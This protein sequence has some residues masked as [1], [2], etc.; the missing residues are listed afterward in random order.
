MNMNM[1]AS[2]RT[3]VEIK[4]NLHQRLE[5]LRPYDSMSWH[6]FIEEMADVYEHERS[7]TEGD[8]RL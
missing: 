3:T 2:N 5:G 4:R 6:E 1:A 7:R 8:T